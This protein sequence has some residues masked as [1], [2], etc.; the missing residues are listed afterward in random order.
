MIQVLVAGNV[1]ATLQIAA[2]IPLRSGANKDGNLGRLRGA[3]PIQRLW[4]V[5]GVGETLSRFMRNGT[6]T[7]K[8]VRQTGIPACFVHIAIQQAESPL[9]AQASMPVFRPLR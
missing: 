3:S 4:S 7:S 6:R 9:G 5:E 8:S 1:P 2:R